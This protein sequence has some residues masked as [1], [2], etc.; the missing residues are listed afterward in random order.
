LTRAL[1]A[2]SASMALSNEDLDGLVMKT[3]SE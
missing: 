2:D 1:W 3:I